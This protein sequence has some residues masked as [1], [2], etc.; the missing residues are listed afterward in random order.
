MER[1]HHAIGK[2][3]SSQCEKLTSFFVLS[4]EGP[5]E[6]I[7][8]Q[9]ATSYHQSIT[10]GMMMSLSSSHRS[11]GLLLIDDVIATTRSF[12]GMQ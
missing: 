12:P 10:A 8:F 1:L 6:P 2:G 5:F 3:I 9:K 7:R 4:T 11:R